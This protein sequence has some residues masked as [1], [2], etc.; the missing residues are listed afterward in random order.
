M[1]KIVGIGNALVDALIRLED[2]EI[3]KEFALP[4]G[5]MT[6]VDKQTMNAILEK[7]TLLKLNMEKSSGGSVANAMH[8]LAQLKAPVGYIGKIGRDR[9]GT[10][11]K[12]YMEQNNICATLFQGRA[13]TGKCIA[14]ISKD[15]ERTFATYLGAAIE[16]EA[17]DLTIG[18]FQGYDYFLLEGYLVQN[19]DLVKKT[20]ALA[21][22]ANAQIAL[23]LA[24]FNI[25]A[26][27]LDFLHAIVDEYID[28][29]F[30]N[31][32]EAKTF[33]GKN[34]PEEALA[35]IA[36]KCDI[37]IVKV[38]K[39]GSLIRQGTRQYRIDPITA[40][41]IDTT[42][43]GDLYASGFF[44]GLACGH[45]LDICGKIGSIVAGHIIEV[46]GAK[47]DLRKWDR[48]FSMIREIEG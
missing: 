7:V 18:P 31:E 14:L 32:D 33:T 34:E 37:A 12:S 46:I 10:F 13:D 8:G 22:Q 4:R 40:N 5:S 39:E 15:S 48:V 35:D 3:L 21:R 29:V 41:G 17:A 43:A 6:L 24:S 1:K 20:V 47:M 9:Y 44:Y 26:A 30:A 19:Y 36:K 11:F 42:G 23:D 28:I 45:P 25:V 16:L 2:D 27:N 38:G